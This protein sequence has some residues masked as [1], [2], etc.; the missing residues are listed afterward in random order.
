MLLE[1][2]FT[3]KPDDIVNA[4]NEGMYRAF[5]QYKEYI[6]IQ[7]QLESR[8]WYL[9]IIIRVEQLMMKIVPVNSGQVP[10]IHILRKK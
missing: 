9:N 1:T 8:I 2:D 10:Q 5:D 4:T 3:Y 7:I 6:K